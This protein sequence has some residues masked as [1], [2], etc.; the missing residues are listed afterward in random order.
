MP[1]KALAHTH[2]W[3]ECEEE[4]AGFTTGLPMTLCHSKSWVLSRWVLTNPMRMEGEEGKGKD[5]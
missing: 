1:C 5:V 2:K 4:S 3:V